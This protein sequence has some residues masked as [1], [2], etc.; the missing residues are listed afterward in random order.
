MSTVKKNYLLLQ[1]HIKQYTHFPV[2][3]FGHPSPFRLFQLITFSFDLHGVCC[4][5]YLNLDCMM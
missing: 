1:L 5:R 4:G 2:D 3:N